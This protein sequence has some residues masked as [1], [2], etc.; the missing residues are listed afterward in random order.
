MATLY[1]DRSYSNC[2]A[3]G[4]NADPNEKAH[5]MESMVGEGCGATFTAVSSNYTDHDGLYDRI[6]EMRPDLPFE[7]GFTWP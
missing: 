2:G 3:C 5:V 4:R 7:G 6:K 1:I